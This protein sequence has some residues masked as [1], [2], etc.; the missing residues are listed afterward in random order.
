MHLLKPI[1]TFTC[2]GSDGET[3][4]VEAALECACTNKG[5]SRALQPTGAVIRC[6]G[7]L[8][9]RVDKGRYRLPTGVELLTDEPDAP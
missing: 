6:G 2:V 4:A 9:V 8:L 1:G 5:G 7:R 3:Y